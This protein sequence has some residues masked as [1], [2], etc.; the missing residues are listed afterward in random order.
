MICYIRQNLQNIMMHQLL[1]NKNVFPLHLL[2][3]KHDFQ[4][5]KTTNPILVC[6]PSCFLELA[7]AHLGKES[8]GLILTPTRY[9]RPLTL[10]CN[11]C[12]KQPKNWGLKLAAR[13]FAPNVQ[14]RR[15]PR[16]SRDVKTGLR[17]IQ[18]S[19]KYVLTVLTRTTRQY[20]DLPCWFIW[21][22]AK[23]RAGLK[24]ICIL[25]KVWS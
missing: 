24:L 9:A 6:P 11:A 8:A 7:P 4:L 25:A 19:N 17:I 10:D 20:C 2:Q 13:A 15:P 16:I 18:S 3:V 14:W 12:L 22:C 1:Y 21:T 5:F 23:P